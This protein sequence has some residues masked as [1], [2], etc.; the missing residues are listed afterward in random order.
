MSTLLRQ[1]DLGVVGPEAGEV[2]LLIGHQHQQQDVPGRQEGQGLMGVTTL[3]A[4]DTQRHQRDYLAH[5]LLAAAWETTTH[6]DSSL[7]SMGANE[8]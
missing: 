6:S 3:S 8:S 5:N 7:S 2:L 1:W 4:G